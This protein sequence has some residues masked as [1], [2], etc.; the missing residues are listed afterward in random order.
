MLR[1]RTGAIS[2]AL[3][4]TGAMAF[5]A[6]PNASEQITAGQAD[7]DRGDPTAEPIQAIARSIGKADRSRPVTLDEAAI[8]AS[9]AAMAGNGVLA[10]LQAHSLAIGMR[11]D[12]GAGMIPVVHLVDCEEPACAQVIDWALD[13]DLKATG[14]I[15]EFGH[16]G[17]EEYHVELR[18][19]LPADVSALAAEA[20]AVLDAVNTIDGAA[21]DNWMADAASTG[22]LKD[23]EGGR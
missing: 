8:E 23:V 9:L 10:Q 16:G 22:I 5:V 1:W 4:V 18:H 13:H 14:P 15:L 20:E 3:V 2:L 7:D 19:H 6:W 11:A 17:V 12:D 21:Y